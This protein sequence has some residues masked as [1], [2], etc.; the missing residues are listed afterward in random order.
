VIW[1]A[2][3]GTDGGRATD[4]LPLGPVVCA[5]IGTG[6]GRCGKSTVASGPPDRLE[7]IENDRT[8]AGDCADFSA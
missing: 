1:D 6:I 4:P 2:R 8:V 3:S 7:E 5:R